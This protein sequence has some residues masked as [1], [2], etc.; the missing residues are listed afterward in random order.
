M[1]RDTKLYDV[2]GVK[3]DATDAQIKKAY[4]LGAL[5]YHPDKNQ[6]NPEAAEKFKE[7][8]SAYEILSDSQK[9]DVYDQYGPEGLTGGGPGGMGGDPGDIFSHF[10]GGGMGG[11]FGGGAPQGPKRSRDIV[12][13]LKA[14]L[15][16]LYVGKVSKLALTRTV[17]CKTCNGK[18][19]KEGAVKTCTA[20]KGQGMKFVT[21]Q[22]GPML[23]RYQTVCNECNGEGK[24]I[25]PKDRCPTCKGKMVHDE[26][27]ILEVNIDKGMANGQKITFS[28]E[29]DQGPD[30]I[31]GDVVFVIDEQPHDRFTRKGDDLHITVEID[32]LTALA[33]GK[34]TIEHVDG[35]YL[36]VE[37]IP[38]EVISP[39]AVKVIEGKGMPSYRH[40]DQGNMYVTFN[41]QFPAPDTFATEENFKKLAEVLPARPAVNVPAG[42]ESEEVVLADVDE[43]KY[44]T[45]RNQY[46]EDMEDAGEGREGVQCASQ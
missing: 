21:R 45:S 33:G 8:S 42:T 40:H 3:P 7:I 27:K 34:F 43:S 2:L 13:A 44:Q 5:K 14:T 11:M 41:V 24:I 15:K 38:G 19:G 9:R 22:M 32:L 10:F 29:G 26:R 16:D 25:N 23:Q 30:I 36:I 31:P 37:I 46:D 12:H 17:L 35:E 6:H 18:G 28:G 20:C 39:G 4:R 1:V